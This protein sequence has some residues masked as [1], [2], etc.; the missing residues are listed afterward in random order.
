MK[1]GSKLL[2]LLLSLFI[3][4]GCSL[5]MQSS[6]YPAWTTKG[7][8]EGYTLTNGKT[9]GGWLGANIGDKIEANWYT[10]KVNKV[11]E[12]DTYDKY[13]AS[14]DNKL[15]HAEIQIKNTSEKDVYIFDEDFALVWDLDKDDINYSYSLK[16]ITDTMVDDEL[17]ILPGEEKTIDTVYEINKKIQKPMAIYYYEQQNGQKGNQYYVY[18]K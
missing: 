14:N 16:A 3:I 4:S 17:I 5:P 12:L 6:K 10:F 13:S 15:V 9:V 7:V 8:L 2:L 11:E 1:R 18:I